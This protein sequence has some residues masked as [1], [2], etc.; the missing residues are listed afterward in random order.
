MIFGKILNLLFIFDEKYQEANFQKLE[1]KNCGSKICQNLGINY[2]WFSLVKG[3][4]FSIK[5]EVNELIEKFAI[6]EYIIVLS[7]IF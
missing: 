3:Q 7:D 4:L 1:E 2:L 6:K 5:I